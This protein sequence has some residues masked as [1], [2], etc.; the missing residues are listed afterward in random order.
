MKTY[1]V[2]SFC[3]TILRTRL[4]WWRGTNHHSPTTVFPSF[5][6]LFLY[7][8]NITSGPERIL[9]FITSS[10]CSLD[11][12]FQRKPSCQLNPPWL[13]FVFTANRTSSLASSFVAEVIVPRSLSHPLLISERLS[14]P[15]NRLD[16]P[17]VYYRW[18]PSIFA[19]RITSRMQWHYEWRERYINKYI[20]KSEN[21]RENFLYM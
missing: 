5:L 17:I 3:H 21:R 8:K 7:A 1:P 20:N 15:F 9:P 4:S 13:S 10:P 14:F 11:H 12:R 18:Q 16:W 19:Y 6:E 2:T